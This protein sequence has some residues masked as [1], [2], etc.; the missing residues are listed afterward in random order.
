MSNGVETCVCIS[1]LSFSGIGVNPVCCLRSRLWLDQTI[2]K[3]PF[4]DFIN[5]FLMWHIIF[6]FFK[7]IFQIECLIFTIQFATKRNKNYSFL[8]FIL[9][10]IAFFSLLS[11]TWSIF[12]AVFV[13]WEDFIY[14]KPQWF[15]FLSGGNPI[16]YRCLRI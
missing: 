4:S 8:F 9:R 11:I 12:W 5:V 7:C 3:L 14:Y 13:T 10:A 6:G 2:Q 16:T 1:F 15:D